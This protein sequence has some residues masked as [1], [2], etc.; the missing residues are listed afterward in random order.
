[1]IEP[2]RSAAPALAW[3]AFGYFACYAP[4][5]ALTKALSKGALP[6]NSG[7]VD[8]VALLPVTSVASLLSMLAFMLLTGWWRYATPHSIGGRRI[9]GPTGLTLASGLATATI[10]ATTTLAYTFPGTS[11]VFMMLLMRGGVL[12]IAPLADWVGRRKV[13]PASWV[14]L[15][16]SFLALLVAM[17][18]DQGW[19]MGW[20]AALD[21]ALYLGAYFFRLRWMSHQAKSEDSSDNLRFFVEEQMV[22]TPATVLGLLLGALLAPGA[23]GL[24]LR[25]G[26]TTV[27][28]DP[29]LLPVG[30]LIGVLSQGTGVVGA[31]ILLDKRENSFCVP[32]N[33]AS[34]IL[35][36]LVATYGL[37]WTLGLARPAAGE[38]VGAGLVIAAIG[39]LSA[40]A[41]HRKENPVR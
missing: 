1:M 37:A 30:L 24:A 26:F 41:I 9:P 27:F 32:I 21:V 7:A 39:V 34:S 12:V 28:T 14:A 16:L 38:L 40:S 36:G 18:G 19:A 5:S 33:R 23:T 6:G 20:G 15:G 31:L 22:A 29:L 3:A 25:A 17:S 13:R 11:I 8:G 10:I 2:K 35:A 4:Y